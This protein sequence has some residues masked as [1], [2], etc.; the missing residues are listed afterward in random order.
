MEKKLQRGGVTS[1]LKS[2]LVP[3]YLSWYIM[4]NIWMAVQDIMKWNSKMRDG[5][6]EVDMQ[7]LGEFKNR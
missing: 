5:K 3:K 7:K 6:N 4:E 2:A 1:T